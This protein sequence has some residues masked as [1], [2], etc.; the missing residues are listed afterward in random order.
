MAQ[1]RADQKRKLGTRTY[2]Q[3]ALRASTPEGSLCLRCVAVTV[4]TVITSLQAV[5]SETIRLVLVTQYH[6]R[7]RDPVASKCVLLD[8]T[9]TG[10][11]TRVADSRVNTQASKPNVESRQ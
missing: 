5:A 6:S 3:Q 2:V 1:R 8:V 11:C 9:K 7:N 10:A 4:A